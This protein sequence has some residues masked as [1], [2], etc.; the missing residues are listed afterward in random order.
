[1][2]ESSPVSRIC[3]ATTT[4][5]WHFSCGRGITTWGQ[6]VS[7]KSLALAIG[8]IRPTVSLALGDHENLDIDSEE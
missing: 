1:M 5:G 6:T 2:V 8:N 4:G 7:R 3:R